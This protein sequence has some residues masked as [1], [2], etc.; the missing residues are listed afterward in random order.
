MPSPILLRSLARAFTAGQATLDDVISRAETMLGRPW[1]WLRPLAKRYIKRFGTGLRPR[2]REVV[3]FLSENK[4]SRKLRVAHYLTVPHVMMPVPV[5]A[6]WDVPA[7]ESAGA[8]AEWLRL[9]PLELDWFSDLKGLAT[10]PRLGHYHYRVLT[11]QG[12]S[13]RLIEA[14]KPRIKEMQRLILAEILERIPSHPA[15]HGFVKHRSILTFVEPHVG[16]RVVVRMDLQDFFPSIIGARIQTVFRLI[17][18]PESVADLLGG[19]CTNAVPP[20]VLR[21]DLYRR[22]HLPQG[23]PTSPALGNICAYRMDCRLAGLAKSVGAAYTRYADDLAFSGDEEFE[24]RLER[25]LPLAAAIVSEEGFTVHHRKTRVMRQGVRQH[26]AGLVTNSHANIMRPD[27][28]RLKATLNNCVRLGPASQNR[29]AH[30]D[31]RAHL[32]GK[33]AFVEMVN[34][35]KGKRLRDLLYRIE[36]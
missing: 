4:R 5:A 19:I 16:R 22:P 21:S 18:Y 23:A 14:P 9:H 25:F 13:L 11:K 26:L 27:F 17:G 15:V 3:E 30:P 31:F 20:S 8:L 12:G 28:D 35:A 7:I 29:E 1:R 10:T 36:W 32:T 2:E 33:V 34:P 24:R 6:T